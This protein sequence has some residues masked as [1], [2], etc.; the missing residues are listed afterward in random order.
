MNA[1]IFDCRY[2]RVKVFVPLKDI[3][4]LCAPVNS[5]CRK[6]LSVMKQHK[7][8]ATVLIGEWSS[9]FDLVYH[10]EGR[11]VCSS[12]PVRMPHLCN[13]VDEC[14]RLLK[15]ITLR[16]YMNLKEWQQ[17]FTQEFVNKTGGEGWGWL[18]AARWAWANICRRNDRRWKGFLMKERTP[19]LKSVIYCV[20]MIW[21]II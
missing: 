9:V 1:L 3:G 20:W 6:I 16:P 4:R 12:R 5:W 7:C 2:W 19:I 10:D 8:L 15:I 14:W 18:F 17:A 11:N 13:I 21:W